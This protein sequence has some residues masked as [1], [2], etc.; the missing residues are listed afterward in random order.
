MA[1][2][3]INKPLQA[4]K[5][6]SPCIVIAPGVATELKKTIVV[7][8][9]E[10]GGTSMGAAVIR[11]LGISMGE[12]AGLN[13]EDPGFLS[14]NTETLKNHIAKR[15]KKNSVW[16]FKVPKASL[17][18]PFYEENLRNPYYVVVYRNVVA[19]IDSWQQRKTGTALGTM[20]H[21]LNYY[22]HI[23]EHMEHTKRPVIMINYERAIADKEGMVATLA[24][25]IGLNANSALIERGVSMMTG[26]G[27]GYVNLPEHFF[28]ITPAPKIPERDAIATTTNAVEMTDDD[29]WVA[30]PSIKKK[31]V[32]KPDGAEFLPKNF[33]IRLQFDGEDDL[34]FATQPL[35]IYFNYTGQMFPGHC[36]R[37]KL[38]RGVN[39]LFIET[40]GRAMAV[41]FG[42][43]H[44]GTRLKLE[45]EFYLANDDDGE[46]LQEVDDSILPAALPPKKGSLLGRLLG[47]KH[48]NKK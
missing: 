23:Q 5:R 31:L 27:Q 42:V 38:Q 28:K 46:H 37:P 35:R 21:I 25:F 30:F 12:R 36:A 34:D 9:V 2:E 7:L 6:K 15:N 19:T 8:G 40:N 47:N 26:D 45:P 10:R 44:D 32:F 3:F 1:E 39:Y 4:T 24:E 29:G 22:R 11:A 48:G 16:G 18:L 17:F 20:G 14:E 33:W 13:H 43:L 41:G